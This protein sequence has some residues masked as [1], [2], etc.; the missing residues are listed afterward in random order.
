MEPQ[1]APDGAPDEDYWRTLAET[2]GEVISALHEFNYWHE[3]TVARGEVIAGL[4]ASVSL[5]RERCEAA[6]AR[7]AEQAQSSPG[8]RRLTALARRAGR[9][10]RRGIATRVLAKRPAG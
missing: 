1:E 2:R 4:E 7:L 3:A 10:T 9:A 5:W 8:S 6:E